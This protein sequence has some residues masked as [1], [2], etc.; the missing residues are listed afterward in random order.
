MSEPLD[1]RRVS[2]RR[3]GTA[4]RTGLSLVAWLAVAAGFA[5]GGDAAPVQDPEPATEATPPPVARPGGCAAVTKAG[6][7]CSRKARDDSTYCTQHARIHGE[8]VVTRTVS[9]KAPVKGEPRKPEDCP[10]FVALDVETADNKATAVCALAIIRFEKGKAVKTVYSLI[11]PGLADFDPLP[12]RLHKITPDRVAGQPTF[13][14]FWK[15]AQPLFQDAAFIVAHNAGFDRAVIA[16][17]CASS[18]LDTPTLPYLDSRRAS[19]AMGAGG[20]LVEACKRLDI[21]LAAHH[22]ESDATAAGLIA[23]RAFAEG[24]DPASLYL[25]KAYAAPAAVKPATVQAEATNDTP[26]LTSPASNP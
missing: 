5:L 17:A 19:T 18:G 21:E 14:A 12:M 8:E 15:E 20:A 26:N 10:T 4:L 16:K 6:N 22:A 24:Y 25:K 13:T 2:R 7:P 23:V 1:G 11:D 9:T 3:A